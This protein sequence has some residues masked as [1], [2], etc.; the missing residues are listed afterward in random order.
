MLLFAQFGELS[1]EFSSSKLGETGGIESIHGTLLSSR[2]KSTGADCG[3]SQYSKPYVLFSAIDV[4]SASI[5]FSKSNVDNGI[6]YSPPSQGLRRS[7]IV[8]PSP[9]Q[10]S[11]YRPHSDRSSSPTPT[12]SNTPHRQLYKHCA[13]EAPLHVGYLSRLDVLCCAFFSS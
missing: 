12:S 10:G 8:L 9:L 11:L 5:E 7:P 1:R 4:A 13:D 3:Q 2:S 6:V